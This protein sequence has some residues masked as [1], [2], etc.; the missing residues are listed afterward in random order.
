MNINLKTLLYSQ[1]YDFERNLK[2]IIPFSW[3]ELWLRHFFFLLETLNEMFLL[4]NQ[5]SRV[6]S[7]V[8]FS[9]INKLMIIDKVRML[10]VIY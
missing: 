10:C 2:V 6:Q 3:P 8:F 7:V 9:F 5:I 4:Q 1:N